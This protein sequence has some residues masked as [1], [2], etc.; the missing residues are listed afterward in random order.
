MSDQEQDCGPVTISI[1]RRVVPGR[2]ADYEAWVQGI[3]AQ[4]L[5]FPGHMGVNVIRPTP[6][7]REYVTIFRFDTYRHSRDWEE[8]EVRAQWLERLEGITEGEDAVQKATGLEFWF[9]LPELPAAHPSP[10]KMALVLLVVVYVM[11][12]V[13]NFLL[14]PLTGDWPGPLRLLLTVLCQVLLMTYLVMPRV[15]RLL[16]SWLFA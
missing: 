2:E 7:S 8:S 14:A 4:A 9:S 1:S 12:T 13:I 6:S 10:H 3:T 16:K 5:K 11:L 15:T